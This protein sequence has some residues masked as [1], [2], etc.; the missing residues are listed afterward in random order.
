MNWTTPEEQMTSAQRKLKRGVEQVKTLCGE[1]S[2][3][4]DAEAYRF[5]S[6]RELRSPQEVVCRCFAVQ[7]KP[8]PL[9]WPLLA[10]E[11][12]QNLRS[13][14]DHLIYEKSEGNERTQFPIFVNP[15][16]FAARAPGMME[17]VPGSVRAIIESHQPYRHTSDEPALDAL[18]ELRTLS[19]LD[20]HKVLATI[21]SAVTREGVGVPHGVDLTWEDYATNKQL[22]AGKA[23]ISTFAVRT[24]GEADDVNVEPIFSYE[25]RIQGRQVGSLKWIGNHVYR[26]MAEVDTGEPLSPFAPY[27]L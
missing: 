27:P 14:L 11:A 21:V 3:F 7:Q 13:A 8:M 25:V 18:A 10:G 19:N 6:E 24:E 9:H 26:V 2:V 22:G 17:G 15:N 4:E 23:Q 16:D 1:T 5:E 12:V 20:K